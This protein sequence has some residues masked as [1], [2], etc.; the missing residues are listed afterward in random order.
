MSNANAPLKTQGFAQGI[1]VQSATQM[2]EIDTVRVLWD[3]R[4]FAYAL[5]GASA[6]AK[7][8][9]TQSA[10][11]SANAQDETLYADVAIGGTVVYVTF[12]GA[13]TANF[14]KGGY[15]W[16]NDDT[17]EGTWY[18]IRGHA[19]GTTAVAV[20][21]DDPVRVAMT[22]GAT[23]ISCIQNRQN[24]VV[25]CPTTLTAPFA[26]VPNIAVDAGY[27]FWNQVKGPCAVLTSGTVVIGNQ[28]TVSGAIGAATPIAE[29]EILTSFGTVMS[30]AATTEYSLINL[31]IPG[32]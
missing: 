1:Y 3:G 8:K 19:A 13:V 22:A 30:V 15:L 24:L 28:V 12:G 17:G 21:L 11:P 2:E 29:S 26:G 27:Y 31:A 5:A 32:Y 4:T 9:I 20:Y 6:L 23:T 10:A 16:A 7:G 25:V 18:R 14:Y